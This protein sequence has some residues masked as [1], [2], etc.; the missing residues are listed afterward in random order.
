MS[1]SKILDEVWGSISHIDSNIV[2]QYEVKYLRRELDQE[3]AGARIAPP[4][5]VSGCA[6]PSG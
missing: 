2:D 3:S 5:G 4:S 6:Q 1:R